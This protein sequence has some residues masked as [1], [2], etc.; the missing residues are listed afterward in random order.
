MKKKILLI[1]DDPAVRHVLVRILA[2]EDYG[3]ISAV[4]GGAG[5]IYAT[6][7]KVDLIL[8]D[9]KIPEKD[10]WASFQ[11]L[12]NLYPQVPVILMTAQSHQLFPAVASGASALLEKPLDFDRLISTIRLLLEESPEVRQMKQKAHQSACYYFPGRYAARS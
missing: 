1:D 11:E 7:V 10:G 4:D 5:L 6:G 2:D 3:T 8:M 12:S 9:L